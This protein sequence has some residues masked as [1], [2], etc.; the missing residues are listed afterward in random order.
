M[1]TKDDEAFLLNV[2]KR[3]LLR[4]LK[5][6]QLTHHQLTRN[7]VMENW[8][9][10]RDR[11]RLW[12]AGMKPGIAAVRFTDGTIQTMCASHFVDSLVAA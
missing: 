12:L 8:D 11:C 4:D 9:G 3:L 10:S 6:G 1:F 7:Y 5:K 2:A